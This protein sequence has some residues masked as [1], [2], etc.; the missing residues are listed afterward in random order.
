MAMPRDVLVAGVLRLISVHRIEP[1]YQLNGTPYGRLHLVRSPPHLVSTTIV[2]YEEAEVSA[3]GLL[4]KNNTRPS[5][6][7][8]SA[9]FF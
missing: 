7:L 3:D 6:F 4:I 9:M 1:S 8:A 5:L 2:A